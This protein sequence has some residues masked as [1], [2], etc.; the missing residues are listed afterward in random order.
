MEDIDLEDAK[1]QLGRIAHHY[2]S[3]IYVQSIEEHF[4]GELYKLFF[5][6]GYQS[7]ILEVEGDRFRDWFMQ[8]DSEPE[9]MVKAI[10]TVVE[11]LAT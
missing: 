6:R 5:Q 8:A 4:D 11:E 9:D 2:D 7:Y 1:Y 3:Q 10:R